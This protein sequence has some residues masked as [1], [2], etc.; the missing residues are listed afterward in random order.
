MQ[1]VSV[2]GALYKELV[3]LS[4][5]EGNITPQFRDFAM[6]ASLDTILFGLESANVERVESFEGLHLLFSNNQH[7][8][9][10]NPWLYWRP[11]FNESTQGSVVIVQGGP[12][13]YN[14]ILEDEGCWQ[15]WYYGFWLP[16]VTA[17]VVRRIG[18]ELQST[19]LS[20][21]KYPPVFED[22]TKHFPEPKIGV[23]LEVLPVSELPYIMRRGAEM[24]AGKEFT[25]PREY[26][27]RVDVDKHSLLS[28]HG[29]APCKKAFDPVILT[30]KNP[31][32]D[33]PN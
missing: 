4:A 26:E 15:S 1:T 19:V 11:E 16:P 3:A 17:G 12:A 33:L 23:R 25:A 31:K 2:P 27:V 24:A 28:I 8:L 21:Q 7:P 29:G 20:P 5:K 9:F 14:H 30:P 6:K 18:N 10:K 13:I 32:T 22:W